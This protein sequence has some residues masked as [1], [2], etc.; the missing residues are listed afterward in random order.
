VNHF[1]EF[2]YQRA[3]GLERHG[4]N[5]GLSRG[6][7]QGPDARCAVQNDRRAESLGECDDIGIAKIGPNLRQVGTLE[8]ACVQVDQRITMRDNVLEKRTGNAGGGTARGIAWK[9][10]I[11]VAA[12]G[13]VS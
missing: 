10:A 11:Q 13:K 3:A 12:I 6:I 7:T 8:R 1:I 9:I 2:E 4:R 5:A